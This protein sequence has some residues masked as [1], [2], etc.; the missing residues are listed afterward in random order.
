MRRAAGEAGGEY[1][2]ADKARKVLE[3]DG[4]E[5]GQCYG[6]QVQVRKEPVGFGTYKIPSELWQLRAE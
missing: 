6:E 3:R 5:Q 1:C 4:E 2:M